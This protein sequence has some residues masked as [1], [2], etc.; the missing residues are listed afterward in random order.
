LVIN[1][2]PEALSSECEPVLR[3]TSLEGQKRWSASGYHSPTAFHKD[4]RAVARRTESA[5]EATILT[6]VVISEYSLNY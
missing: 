6:R 4:D 3:L 1:L 2:S 5:N